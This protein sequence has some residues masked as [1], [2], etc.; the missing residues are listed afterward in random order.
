MQRRT[1][2]GLSGGRFESAASEREAGAAARTPQAAFPPGLLFPG[3][4]QGGQSAQDI[5][6][7]ILVP[8]KQVREL[9]MRVSSVCVC[10]CPRELAT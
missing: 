8:E 10:V 2:L 6:F 4:R 9:S 7:L 3:P 1:D 5:R